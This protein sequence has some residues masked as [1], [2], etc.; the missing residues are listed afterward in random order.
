MFFKY[1][2]VGRI[3]DAKL[4]FVAEIDV[5]LSGRR[6]SGMRM[7]FTASS[8][9]F[10]SS[11]SCVSRSLDTGGIDVLKLL[12]RLTCSVSA[13]EQILIEAIGAALR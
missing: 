9:G 5:A 12:R 3:I 1:D 11:W 7:R 10:K 13:S 4:I 6:R 8:V 2:D